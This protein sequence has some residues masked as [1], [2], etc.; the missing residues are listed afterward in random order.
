MPL[1]LS[2][3]LISWNEDVAREHKRLLENIGVRVAPVIARSSGMIGKISKAASSVIV[4][5][6][7]A[8]PAYGR[9]AA[10]VFR[11]SPST[12]HLPLVFAGGL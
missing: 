4:I 8:K 5:D 2:V 12:R 7:D 3:A 1:K 10:I 11:N 6:L 9:E